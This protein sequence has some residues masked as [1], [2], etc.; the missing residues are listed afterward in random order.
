VGAE[1][2][3]SPKIAPTAR[4]GMKHPPTVVMLFGES[5]AKR[6]PSLAVGAL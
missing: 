2:F 4:E 1:G 5:D 6:I 3:P